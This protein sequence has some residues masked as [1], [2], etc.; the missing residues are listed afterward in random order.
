M[1]AWTSESK[2]LSGVNE[3]G[4]PFVFEPT[5]T[6][7]QGAWLGAFILLGVLRVCR[8]RREDK[9]EECM[10]LAPEGASHQRVR[11]HSRESV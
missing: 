9:E 10:T 6:K 8:A 4:L 3:D 11:A 5:K 1:V 2:L 7:I